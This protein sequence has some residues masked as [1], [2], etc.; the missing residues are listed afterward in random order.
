MANVH[1]KKLTETNSEYLY[2]PSQFPINQ[3]Q[4]VAFSDSEMPLHE[5]AFLS[6]IPGYNFIRKTLHISGSSFQIIA[7][8]NNLNIVQNALNKTASRMIALGEKFDHHNKKSELSKLNS[9][10]K[11]INASKDLIQIINNALSIGKKTDGLF[12]IT[13]LPVITLLETFGRQSFFPDKAAMIDALSLV[14]YRKIKISNNTISLQNTGMGITLGGIGKGFIID[15]GID[16]LSEHGFNNILINAGNNVMSLGEKAKNI[17]WN[18]QVPHPRPKNSKILFS[19]KIRDN[20]V[21]TSGDYIHPFCHHLPNHHVINPKTGIS[22][23][24]LSSCTI[25]SPNAALSDALSTG[26]LVM[27]IQKSLNIIDNYPGCEALF[28]K[29]DLSIQ[30]TKG[31]HKFL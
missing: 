31:F 23:S 24:E 6:E 20:A 5:Q 15:Q 27:G 9:T 26:A 2:S 19:M 16:V 7:Y 25:T 21:S 28:V 13:I 1:K 11:I 29:K 18:V 8:G 3:H 22:P 14:D 4:I 17:P 12:D 10:G 30:K